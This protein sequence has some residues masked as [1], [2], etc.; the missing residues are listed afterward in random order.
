MKN[1]TPL[2][3]RN[4]LPE[5][6]GNVV[7]IELSPHAWQLQDQAGAILDDR[8]FDDFD[9]ARQAAVRLALAQAGTVGLRDRAGRPLARVA[10]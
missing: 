7:I 1:S 6:L 10:A 2:M 5:H 4:P 9:E 8:T 3:R